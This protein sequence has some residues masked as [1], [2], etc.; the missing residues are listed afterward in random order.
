MR[1]LTVLEVSQK[2]NYIYKTERLAENIGASMIIREITED[3]PERILGNH[4]NIISGGGGNCLLDFL[5]KKEAYDFSKA[6]S[7]K[8]LTDYPGVEL[9]L[10]SVEYDEE[11]DRIME[12]IDELYEKLGAKKADRDGYFQIY[13]PGI[14]ELCN[15]TQYPAAGK[16]SRGKF[17][18]AECLA[19]LFRDNPA[20]VPAREQKMFSDWEFHTDQFDFFKEMLPDSDK[21][22]FANEFEELGGTKNVKDYMAVIFI[23]GNKMGKKLEAFKNKFNSAT[24]DETPK[25][26]NALYKKKYGALSEAL[27]DSYRAAVKEAIGKI[28]GMLPEFYEKGSLSQNTDKDS[29]KTILPIRPLVLSG[30]DICIVCDARISINLA[31]EILKAIDHR[32]VDVGEGEKMALHA[33]AGIAMVK[34][35]YPFF[36]AHELAEELCDNAKARF[37]SKDD[38]DESA[39]DFLIVQGEIEGSLAEIEK[40]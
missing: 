2:Q 20:N 31:E 40:K 18:S 37:S 25:D 24:K 35:H 6:F 29:K 3:L 4:M 11:K 19:K 22:R 39:L 5:S 32:S 10:A 9:F 8:V 36:R 1:Y 23:D 28:T 30:D 14:T 13:S 16:D 33:C 38:E 21:Y 34:S 17:V 26:A 7:T 27:D 12:K 15:D